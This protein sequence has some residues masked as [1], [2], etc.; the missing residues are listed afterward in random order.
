MEVFESDKKA[1]QHDTEAL[2]GNGKALKY[3]G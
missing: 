3:D 2:K 1:S